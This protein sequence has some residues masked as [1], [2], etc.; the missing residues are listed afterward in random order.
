MPTAFRAKAVSGVVPAFNCIVDDF[1]QPSAQVKRRESGPPGRGRR[2]AL[3]AHP[4]PLNG[5]CTRCIVDR[6]KDLASLS[7]ETLSAMK[8]RLT[9]W[10]VYIGVIDA[11]VVGVFVWIVVT[12]PQTPIVALIPVLLLPGIALVPFVI[13]AGAVRRELERRRRS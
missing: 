10:I 11:V 2:L 13:R 12:R 8:A 5:R 4:A 9:N 7:T 3:G 1:E 6:M